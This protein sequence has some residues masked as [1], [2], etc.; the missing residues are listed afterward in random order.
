MSHDAPQGLSPQEL[1]QLLLKRRRLWLVP[2]VIGGALGLTAAVL[3][4]RKWEASQSLHVRQEAT[5]GQQRPGSFSS[6]TEMKTLQETILEVAKSK[7][8]L[9]ATLRNAGPPPN[10]PQPE[11]W[12]SLEAIESLRGAVR[13]TPPGGA[14]FGTTEVVYLK[15]RSQ[16]R[17]RALAVTSELCEQ[18]ASRFQ[19]VRGQ[20]A[21]S[22]I[23]E[24][25]KTVAL[26]E[27]DLQTA[28]S[29]LAELEA[30]V[31]VD[32]GELRILHAS[33][34]GT[35]SLRQR[36]VAMEAARREQESLQLKNKQLLAL[37]E[38]ARKDPQAL[39]ATPNSLL[40]TQPA[41][42]RL[43]EGLVDAQL[44][45]ARLKGLRSPEHPLVIAAVETQR[46]VHRQLRNE[47]DTAIKGLEL[48]V[49]LAQDAAALLEEK[50]GGVSSRLNRLA[51]LRANYTNLVALAENRTQLLEAARKNLADARASQ[52]GARSA[53]LIGRID[54][55][56]TGVRPVGPGRTAVA[57]A[58]LTGGL[59]CGLGLVF[60]FALPTRSGQQAAATP[61][62][63]PV[64]SKA[65]PALPV[66]EPSDPE[67]SVA[68]EGEVA[69][70][71]PAEAAEP[72]PLPGPS[73]RMT[74]R[75]TKLP[76]QSKLPE[77]Q[78]LMSTGHFGLFPGM[79][80]REAMCEV[81][82]RD[83]C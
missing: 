13:M 49:R 16:D 12:P 54:D 20:R 26:A 79:T 82:R 18:L 6:L 42:Q 24:L 8:V 29:Q 72:A 21:Q 55:P 75:H 37:L 11:N 80:L 46:E 14:E 48:D 15:V 36:L 60:L 33:P 30:G 1:L 9:E 52:A 61:T 51:E 35:S 3:M 57:S 81:A 58:G 69:A 62:T 5:T 38:E 22:M 25:E 83:A 28:T 66:A 53:S 47:L 63:T 64:E 44:K 59:L 2:M 41:L 68:A 65:S 39:I 10:K 50:S 56:D 23:N 34:S 19:Q 76:R 45:T 4:P 70:R 71:A 43:K 77:V 27:D 7:S 78:P 32:L 74:I 73:P 40:V 17:G 67:P 31:G